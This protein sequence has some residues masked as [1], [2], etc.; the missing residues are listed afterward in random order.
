MDW[1]DLRY[2]VAL[3]REGSLSGAARALRAEHST[4]ARRIAA[5]EAAL[6]L[7]LFDR[8]PRGYALTAEGEQVAA[9]A[10][11]LEEDVLAIERLAQGRAGDLAGSVR[12]SAPPVL[13]SHFLAARLAPLRARHPGLLLELAGASRAVSLTR[14]EAD[15]AIRLVRPEEGALVVRRLGEM[16]YGLY[17]AADYLAR[18]APAERDWMGYDESLEHVPQQRWLTALAQGRPL[19]LRTNDLAT[20]HMAARAGLGLAALPRFLGDADPALVRLPAADAGTAA[21]EIWLLVH[22]DLRRS[23]RVR[24]VMDHLEAVIHAGRGLLAGEG[25]GV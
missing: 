13:A 10:E 5:L 4:V 1:D 17:G 19:A 24:A 3:A 11:R 23:A 6:G 15:L 16:A 20:L 21:R 8:L 9:L 14:R 7:R 22:A 25:E 2:L 18:R 12:I